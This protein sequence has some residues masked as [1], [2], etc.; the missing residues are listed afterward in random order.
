L[1]DYAALQA[2]VSKSE[3]DG[4]SDAEVSAVL[5]AEFVSATKR[6]IPIGEVQRAAFDRGKL[7]AIEAAASDSTNPAQSAAAAAR[8]L[9]T[10]AKFD[11][12]NPDNEI[13]TNAI[14]GLQQA[15][16]ITAEDAA[17]I[18]GLGNVTTTRAL[19]LDGWNQPTTEFDIRAARSR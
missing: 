18:L 1:P 17:Y 19:S 3:F 10:Q 9:W 15:N 2:E 13:F 5:N 14:A 12:V 11:T 4:K 6:L 16:L 8:W 7:A